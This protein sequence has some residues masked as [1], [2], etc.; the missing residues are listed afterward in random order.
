MGEKGLWMCC[1]KSD[2]GKAVGQASM[3][4]LELRKKTWEGHEGWYTGTLLPVLG[5]Q[6]PVHD[7]QRAAG[8]E[9]PEFFIG[10]W[11]QVSMQTWVSWVSV[12][13]VILPRLCQI[14]SF[15][16]KRRLDPLF[17]YTDHGHSFPGICFFATATLTLMFSPSLLPCAN[18]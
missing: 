9:C 13:K 1:R 3:G 7:Q 15:P 11:L 6:E 8:H 16:E 12:S 4:P 5:M 18:H 10:T 14:E 17:L 2:T